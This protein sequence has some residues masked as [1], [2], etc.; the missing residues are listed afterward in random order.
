MAAMSAPA[1]LATAFSAPDKTRLVRHERG[2]G[3]P[4]IC[5]PGGPMRASGYLGDLGG[6]SPRRRLVLLDLRGTGD[7]GVPDDPATYRVDRQVGDVEALRVDLG[8][9]QV[10]L[11][12][13]SAAGDLAVLYAAGHPDRVRSLVLVTAR[14]RALGIDFTTAQRREAAKLRSAEPWFAGAYPSFEAL[15]KPHGTPT[16]AVWDAAAPFWYGRWDAA[17][18]AHAAT[19]VGQTNEPGSEA[20]A[21]PAAFD[22][23]STRA[24]IARLGARVL[25]LAGEWDGG[26]RPRTAERIAGFFPRCEL[27]VQPGAGHFPWLDDPDRF[28]GTVADFLD[29]SG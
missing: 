24:A 1:C 3:D 26:P 15:W 14:G 23:P 22:P 4:L 17:A 7:S 28:V 19:E 8:L 20:Y 13:H 2:T 12:A 11:L 25:F 27:V 5:L 9:E 16:D 18:Q 21:A 6:L 29:A 10:D